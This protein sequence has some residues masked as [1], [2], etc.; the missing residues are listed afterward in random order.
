MSVKYSYQGVVAGEIVTWLSD[1]PDPSGA[2]GPTGVS[3]VIQTNYP[4]DFGFQG[5]T[6]ETGPTGATGATGPVANLGYVEVIKTAEAGQTFTWALSGTGVSAV[7]RALKFNCNN[8][9]FDNTIE[10]SESLANGAT[11]G[12]ELCLAVVN[13]GGDVLITIKSGSLTPL[14]SAVLNNVRR[15]YIFNG[16]QWEDWS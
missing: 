8:N 9:Y 4:Q 12:A 14:E 5:A 7:G 13:N 16:T 1:G 10:L 6:G 2:S 15:R 3:A 11:G